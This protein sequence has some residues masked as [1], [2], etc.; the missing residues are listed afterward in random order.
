[1]HA[2]STVDCCSALKEDGR[3]TFSG[4]TRLGVGLL[5]THSDPGIDTDYNPQS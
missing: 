4:I 1:V 3:S 5:M 2:A